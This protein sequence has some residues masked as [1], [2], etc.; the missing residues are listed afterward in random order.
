M[1]IKLSPSYLDIKPILNSTASKFPIKDAVSDSNSIL[2]YL[3][4]ANIAMHVF[5]TKQ[6][7][8][9]RVW[10]IRSHCPSP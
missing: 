2:N 8:K 1:N 10:L 4:G 9:L 6:N 7:E 3:E 5:N